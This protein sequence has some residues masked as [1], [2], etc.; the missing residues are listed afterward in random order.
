MTCSQRDG[1]ARAS[2]IHTAV[3]AGAASVTFLGESPRALII[4]L[5]LNTGAYMSGPGVKLAPTDEER[6]CVKMRSEA[7]KDRSRP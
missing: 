6:R 5:C 1:H 3:A 7:D 2:P 4:A